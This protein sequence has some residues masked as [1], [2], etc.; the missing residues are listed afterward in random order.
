M[1]VQSSEKNPAL[2]G[3]EYSVRRF[4]TDSLPERQRLAAWREEFGRTMVRTDIEPLT[5][6]PIQAEATLG[7]L[8]EFRWLDFHGSAMRFHR[9]RSLAASGDD[10]IGLIINRGNGS[11]LSHRNRDLTLD[12]GDACAVLTFEPGMISA[13]G[14]L[15][16]LFPRA[17]LASR[18]KNIADLAAN[19]IAADADELR[20]LTGYFNALPQKLE[21]HSARLQRTLINHLYDL[22]ALVMCPDRP[23]DENSLSAT[24]AARLELA[25]A[26]LDK[27]FDF[28]GLTISAVASNQN[29]SPRYL[30]R[31][32]ETTGS[33]FSERLSELRLQ[34][35][36]T[37]LTDA[38]QSRKRIA[39]IALRSGFSD[40]SYFNRIFR[41]RF[42]E[43]P[44]G[45]RGRM[46]GVARD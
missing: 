30:Q 44:R 40:V 7:Q 11:A 14:H 21:A 23:A 33:T 16:F 25:L 2:A 46:T 24:A 45:M 22:I 34:R 39:E 4:A 18:L 32:I 26:Y 13:R 8:M 38:R 17:A 42:G 20:L 9:T 37:L 31:L 10:Y 36:L 41:K 5:D 15:D 3:P 27:H 1:E 6:H 43:T 19:R 35:A 29:I 28:P 12:D